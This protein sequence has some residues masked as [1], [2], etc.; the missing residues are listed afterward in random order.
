LSP[1]EV[2]VEGTQASPR[3]SGSG[4]FWAEP[5]VE[6]PLYLRFPLKET[7]LTLSGP[8]HQRPIRVRLRGDEV[9]AMDNLGT[10]FTFFDP[11]E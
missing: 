4:L 9:V 8:R 6:S 10:D 7:E 2:E 3:P 1:G 11:Y 5:P